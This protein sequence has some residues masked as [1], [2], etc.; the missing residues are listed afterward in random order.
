VRDV[1]MV[2]IS[3]SAF[4]LVMTLGFV[5]GLLALLVAH[6][7]FWLRYRKLHPES[8]LAQTVHPWFFRYMEG[9]APLR[10]LH[11]PQPEPEL[12]RLRRRFVRVQQFGSALGLL[13]L[14]MIVLRLLQAA[15]G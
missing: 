8:R 15:T 14:A 13:L 6:R 11:T 1:L 12:E 9:S 10:I 7:A 5:P 3:D 2:V 4:G